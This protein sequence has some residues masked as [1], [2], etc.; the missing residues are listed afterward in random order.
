MWALLPVPVPCPEKWTI[1]GSW[2]SKARRRS[3]SVTA[4]FVTS[5]KSSRFLAR[6]RT[7]ST[8]LA[9]KSRRNGSVP[10][11]FDARKSIVRTREPL[12]DLSPDR[13]T[14]AKR[15]RVFTAEMSFMK[16]ANRSWIREIIM[17][18]GLESSVGYTG[19][20]HRTRPQVPQSPDTSR[21]ASLHRLDSIR[22]PAGLN[23]PATRSSAG[24]VMREI[25][26]GLHKPEG[27]TK[28]RL[29]KS[30]DNSAPVCFCELCVDL[31]GF[32]GKL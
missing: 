14:A 10:F 13:T 19:S 26:T 22:R 31:F 32:S 18:R 28:Q 3:T 12:Q 30:A 6:S 8:L 17:T 23:S 11:G 7:C 27:D 2:S 16:V 21:L 15:S 4:H 29:T 24:F 9:S 5:L 1:S 25:Q 20:V